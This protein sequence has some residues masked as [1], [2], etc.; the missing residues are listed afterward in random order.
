[1]KGNPKSTAEL[2]PA[3][4]VVNTL[5]AVAWYKSTKAKDSTTQVFNLTSNASRRLTWQSLGKLS[6]LGP[7]LS[8]T[9]KQLKFFGMTYICEVIF[10]FR[11]VYRLP[12]DLHM[13]YL[14]I[15]YTYL[16]TL[17]LT[18]SLIT[19]Q[20]VCSSFRKNPLDSVLRIPEASMTKN[21]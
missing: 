9:I 16:L 17:T 20:I 3:D 8:I 7:S 10:W 15:M 5:L 6:E 4:S 12:D 19:E 14:L 13:E 1:M 11:I 2:I 18:Y 21:R